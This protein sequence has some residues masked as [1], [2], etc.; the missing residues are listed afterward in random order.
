MFCVIL[1][2]G[3]ILVESGFEAR[4]AEEFLEGFE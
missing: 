4:M 2:L 3:P 1:A